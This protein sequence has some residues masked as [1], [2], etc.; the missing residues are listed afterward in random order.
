MTSLPSF[1]PR[2]VPLGSLTCSA[3]QRKNMKRWT[4]ALLIVGLVLMLGLSSW[5]AS[6]YG[7]G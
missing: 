4:L 3:G 1:P 6:V 7:Q 2:P 5:L